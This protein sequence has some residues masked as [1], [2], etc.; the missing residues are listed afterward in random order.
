MEKAMASSTVSSMV[1]DIW[2]WPMG[3]R[4]TPV[5]VWNGLLYLSTYSVRAD[6][7][8]HRSFRLVF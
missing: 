6:S 7:L 5:G 8:C 2:V 1:F 4:L 3:E